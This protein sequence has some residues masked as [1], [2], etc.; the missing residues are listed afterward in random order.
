MKLYPRENY[1]RKIRGFYHDTG[2]IK[3]ISGVR[4]CGKSSLMHIIADELIN[5]GISP[6]NIVFIDLK[7]HGYKS[8]KT[9][10]ALE[11]TILKET[12]LDDR[13]YLFIDEIQNVR[14]F[15]DV[16]EAFRGEGNYSIFITGSNSYMLSSELSTN[17]TGRYIEFEMFPLTF[18]EYI[19]MKHFYQKPAD[20]NLAAELDNYILEGG[21]PKAL[22]YDSLMDKRRYVSGIIQEI[23]EKD[24]SHRVQIRNKEAFEKIQTYIINNFG[25]TTNLTNIHEDLKKAGLSIK[26]ETLS[27]YIDVLLSAK[28]IYKCKRFD[29]KSRKSLRGEEKY[30]LSDLAFYF[31]GNTD[32]RINYGPVL[33]NI[34]YSYA[35][36]KDYVVSIGKIGDY[37]CDFIFRDMN[38]NYSYAQVAMTILSS[39][40]TEDREYRPFEK[41]KDNYPK[42]LLTRAD[43]IQKRDGIIH[44]NIPDFLSSGKLF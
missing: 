9:P 33:E 29:L 41:I 12:S 8:I 44:A 16:I 22:E 11:D 40:E 13:I 36:S 28:I 43:M 18:E 1:L 5:G 27:H 3:I 7:K 14:G 20:L 4:R 25:A 34:I 42:Y 38:L 21:F 39:R 30:Y 10:Q 23:Y 24:I 31:T 37:K 2:M 17:L 6:Q 35:K 26:R 19:G 32:N 15:E